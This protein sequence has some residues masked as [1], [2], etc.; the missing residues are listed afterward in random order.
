M[1]ERDVSVEV[2]EPGLLT[3]VQTPS[4]RIGWRHLGVPVGGAAD[5]W[6]ARL[7]NRLVGNPDDAAALEITLIGPVLRLSAPASLA[8]TGSRFAAT[9]DGLPVPPFTAMRARAGSTLRVGEGDGARAYLAF[10]GGMAVP[11]LLG[12]A[13]TDLRSGFGGHDGRALRAGDRLG[14]GHAGAG[15]GGRWTGHLPAGPIRITPGP[16]QDR[17]APDALTGA[18]WTVGAAADRSGVRLDGGPL[19]TT[20]PEVATMG[21]PP[22]A[23]QVPPDGRPIV[24]LADRPVTGGYPVPACVI[25]ADVGRVAQL[26]TGDRVEFMFVSPGDAREAYRQSDAALAWLEV[27]PSPDADDRLGWAGAIE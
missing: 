14:V 27:V 10:G 1:A 3:S 13:A 4:G 24:M 25:R 23:I 21:L 19:A 7:A 15:V 8:L 22:G 18:P 20:D 2:L 16:H 11:E 12:S 17:V 26:R 6:S 9:L 5:A